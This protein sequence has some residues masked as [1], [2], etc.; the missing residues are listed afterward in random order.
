MI[1]RHLPFQVFV[2]AE[3]V[4]LFGGR[5]AAPELSTSFTLFDSFFCNQN[6]LLNFRGNF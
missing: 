3:P 2:L 5:L 1:P 6:I 4:T